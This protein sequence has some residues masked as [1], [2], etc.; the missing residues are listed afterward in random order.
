MALNIVHSGP[1][2]SNPMRGSAEAFLD[3][4]R[5]HRR[6]DDAEEA[7][8]DS[9]EYYR[10]MFAYEGGQKRI[11]DAHV[12]GNTEGALAALI[13]IDRINLILGGF[14][15]VGMEIDHDE[16]EELRGIKRTLENL[17]RYHDRAGAD[18]ATREYAKYVG[19]VQK[20]DLVSW[21]G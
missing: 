18:P 2:N 20:N 8:T 4:W 17:W 3:A 14:Y 5:E 9:A 11:G 13:A 21:E 6:L 19:A 16:A 12:R 1:S 7:Q 10:A 15:A